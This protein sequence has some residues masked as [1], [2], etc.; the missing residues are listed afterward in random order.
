MSTG[1]DNG[2][3]SE[4]E[5]FDL[6]D[7]SEI[8]QREERGNTARDRGEY[9]TARQYYNEAITIADRYLESIEEVRTNED[10]SPEQKERLEDLENRLEL[11]NSMLDDQIDRL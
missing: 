2:S 6:P 11:Y 8:L 5:E 4:L 1:A 3:E 9:S 10:L 7:I